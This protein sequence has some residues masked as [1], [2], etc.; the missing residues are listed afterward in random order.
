MKFLGTPIYPVAIIL[1]AIA[2]VIIIIH[3]RLHL[4]KPGLHP[5]FSGIELATFCTLLAVF[6]LYF[7]QLFL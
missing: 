2:A 4:K 3:I 6:I 5:I 1:S 7:H